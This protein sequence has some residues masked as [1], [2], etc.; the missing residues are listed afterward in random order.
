M[1]IS[2]IGKDKAKVLASLYNNAKPLGLGIRQYDPKPMTEEEASE[3]LKEQTY[4][5]YL[6]GRIMKVDLSGDSLE[7][8]LY[9]RD[10]GEGSAEAI[11]TSI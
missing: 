10:N 1:V 4:F 3:L 2:L 8:Y 6:K 7:T 5:D 9:N 11:L